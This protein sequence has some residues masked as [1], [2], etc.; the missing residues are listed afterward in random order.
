MCD[1]YHVNNSYFS[2]SL[3]RLNYIHRVT[4]YLSV[5]YPLCYDE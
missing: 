4:S 3:S 5:F 2:T 1:E